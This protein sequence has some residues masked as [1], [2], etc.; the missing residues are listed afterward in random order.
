MEQAFSGWVEARD[1]TPSSAQAGSIVHIGPPLIQDRKEKQPSESPPRFVHQPPAKYPL[2]A[3][4]LKLEGTVT[5][6]LELLPDGTVGEVKVTRSS[7][8]PLLDTAAQNAVR[9]WTHT[10][11]TQK[12]APVT[13]WVK[14]Q[15]AFKLDD[16]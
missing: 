8:H 2:L 6:L 12:T 7:G 11:A 13:Q 5:L 1:V 14:R 16:K 9:D 4:K 3:K 10:S 15:I